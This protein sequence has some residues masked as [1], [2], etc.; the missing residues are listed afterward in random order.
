MSD[1]TKNLAPT[2]E[3]IPT[4]V[5]W[6]HLLKVPLALENCDYERAFIEDDFKTPARKDVFLVARGCQA[7][8][9]ND[10][11][12]NC[13]S[14][15]CFCGPK[16][17]REPNGCLDPSGMTVDEVATALIKA[18]WKREGDS[19][20]DIGCVL[21]G[22]RTNPREAVTHA[23]VRC[24]TWSMQHPDSTWQSKMGVIGPIV[25]HP[26]TALD[27]KYGDEVAWFSRPRG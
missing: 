18:G 17:G 11:A 6:K 7:I 3:V 14:W 9:S 2:A 22:S 25:I 20:G 5:D 8:Q 13:I 24:D 26:R 21:L 16:G 15:A 10:L 12:F 27:T 1:N 4:T 19:S 23:M